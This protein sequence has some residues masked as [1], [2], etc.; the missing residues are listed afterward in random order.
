MTQMGHVSPSALAIEA[1]RRTDSGAGGRQGRV[2][3]H[4]L[5]NVWTQTRGG[6]KGYLRAGVVSA[7]SCRRPR[8]G[9]GIDRASAKGR[10]PSAHDYDRHR[11]AWHAGEGYPE[12]RSN[13]A[14]FESLREGS[15]PP[16][17]SILSRMA[18]RVPAGW[19]RTSPP[20]YRRAWPRD[21][22]PSDAQ[23]SLA[24]SV[25]TWEDMRWLRKAWPGPIVVKGVLTGDDARRALD[26]GAVGVVVSNHGGRQLDGTPASLRALPEPLRP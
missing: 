10:L 20:Q 22:V 18:L 9:R 24:R 5:N 13:A 15:L 23:S 12:R 4:P 7:L 17:T 6:C 1:P 2:D 25:V 8:R 16:P 11:H 3:L 14:W 19:G 26:E 21:A